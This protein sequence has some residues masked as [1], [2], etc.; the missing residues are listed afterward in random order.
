[1]LLAGFRRLGSGA[2]SKNLVLEGA[3][4][5]VVMDNSRYRSCSRL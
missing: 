5:S 2:D 4:E 1:M 3:G